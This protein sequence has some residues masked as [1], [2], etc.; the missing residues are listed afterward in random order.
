MSDIKKIT[1]NK[2]VAFFLPYIYIINYYLIMYNNNFVRN[3]NGQILFYEVIIVSIITLFLYS[4]FYCFIKKLFKNNY[5]QICILCFAI[6]TLLFVQDKNYLLFI[7]LIIILEMLYLLTKNVYYIV[8]FSVILYSL[9]IFI[10]NFSITTYYLTYTAFHSVKYNDNNEIVVDKNKPTPNIYWIHCDAMMGID[11]MEKYYNYDNKELIDYFDNNDYVYNKKARLVVGYGTRR[12]LPALFNP[13]FYD[14]VLKDYLMDLEDVFLEKKK[15]TDNLIN[16][17]ELQDKRLN[18]ELIDLLKKKDYTTYSIGSFDQYTSI[19]TDYYYN[20]SNV[21]HYST[22]FKGTLKKTSYKENKKLYSKQI[23]LLHSETFFTNTY[24]DSFIDY[25]KIDV[26]KGKKMNYNDVNLTDY[27]YI[28][29]TK[30]APIKA[31]VKSLSDLMKNNN[32]K[33]VFID[34]YLT[35][36]PYTFFED[37]SPINNE[38]YSIYYYLNNYKYSNLLLLD[39]IKYISAYDNDSIIVVQGDHGIN[40]QTDVEIMR[41]FNI[42]NED[43]QDIRNSVIN[44]VY[45]PKK[46]RV[47]DEQYLS[48]PLNISR[49]LINNYVGDNY[50]YLSV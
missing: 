42:S 3:N 29:N 2:Y 7:F 35:H 38:E 20:Y 16:Y 22:N 26:L 8:L 41:Y 37:G 44:A 21:D 12:A 6:S 49:Y 50:K 33:F 48:E 11:V 9:L 19:Y 47:G 25:S 32:Q 5:S 13:D 30:Y 31:T 45:I 10:Y 4:L 34:Y 14:N 36:A 40:T 46:Y 1:N 27:K 39:L 28:K 18:N 43:I 15:M 23:S 24:L 17:Y